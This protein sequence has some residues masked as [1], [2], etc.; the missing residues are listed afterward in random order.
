MIKKL[1]GTFLLTSI[2]LLSAC[3]SNQES[4]LP[5]E[6]KPIVNIEQNIAQYIHV[7]A[8]ST[9]LVIENTSEQ[10]AQVV[11]K[12]FWYDQE[13]VTQN[14]PNSVDDE[15]HQLQ[16]IPKEKREISVTKPTVESEN[17][18]VYLRRQ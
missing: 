13:G 3:I 7:D 11:Y 8:K 15:W 4:Y 14:S 6:N 18:R 17:Y 5:V 2:A 9:A 1:K 12:L 10:A 16:L